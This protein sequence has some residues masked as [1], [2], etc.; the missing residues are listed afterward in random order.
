MKEIPKRVIVDENMHWEC[1]KCRECCKTNKEVIKKIFGMKPDKNECPFLQ[2]NNCKLENNK[3]L[4]CKLYPFFPGIN[5][6]LLSFAIGKLTV[7]AGC[8]GLGKGK[9]VAENKGLLEKIDKNAKELMERLV[10]K[11][12]GK[13]K[14][15]FQEKHESS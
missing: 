6:N 13:I 1:Q 15:V 8:P 5:N 4:I 2:N 12:Q 7:F 9:K 14:G 10:L 3:P 11:S